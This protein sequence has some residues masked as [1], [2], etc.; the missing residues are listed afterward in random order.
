MKTFDFDGNLPL[1]PLINPVLPGGMTTDS[2]NAFLT[3]ISNDNTPAGILMRTAVETQIGYSLQNLG[4]EN[5]VAFSAK[6]QPTIFGADSTTPVRFDTLIAGTKTDSTIRAYNAIQNYIGNTAGVINLAQELPMP[7]MGIPGLNDMPIMP[8]I[9]GITVSLGISKIPVVNNFTVGLRYFP[10]IDYSKFGMEGFEFGWFGLKLQYSF[11]HFVP[12]VKDLKW[13]NASVSW[14]MNNLSI[15]I[16]TDTTGG[17]IS[18]D[19]KNWIGALNVSVDKNFG[20]IGLGVFLGVAVEHSNLTLDVGMPAS[21]NMDDFSIEIEGDNKFRF[22]VGPRIT[23]AC[24][25]IWGDVNLGA[26][27]SYT[28]GINLLSFNGHGL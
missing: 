20:P 11:L 10:S 19:Q 7:F 28:V 3:A 21:Y 5:Q 27:T 24:I 15:G 1:A 17:S 22:Q 18:M 6:D 12:V 4:I 26:T 2:I 9:P 25:E 16:A 14:A 23:L 8:S 13:L